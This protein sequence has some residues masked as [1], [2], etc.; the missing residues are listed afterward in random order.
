MGSIGG[1]D[2]DFVYDEGLA[3]KLKRKRFDFWD[4]DINTCSDTLRRTSK[5][6]RL[7]D[8]MNKDYKKF[9]KHLPGNSELRHSERVQK[10]E[11]RRS[12]REERPGKSEL[13]HSVREERDDGDGDGDGMDEDYKRFLYHLPGNSEFRHSVREERDDGDRSDEDD[14]ADPQYKMFLEKLKEDGKSYVLEVDINIKMS[15][16]RKYEVEVDLDDERELPTLR[17]LMKVPDTMIMETKKDLRNLSRKDNIKT[18]DNPMYVVS[19][20][21]LDPSNNKTNAI[22]I[23]R[24]D[25]LLEK[26]LNSEQVN[27][28]SSETNRNHLFK[29]ECEHGTEADIVMDEDYQTFLNLS[30]EEGDCMILA[31]HF[32][33]TECE[34]GTETSIVMDEDYQTL[35]NLSKEEG[36]CTVLAMK[37]GEQVTMADPGIFIKMQEDE[38][39]FLGSLD[40]GNHSEFRDKLVAKLREPYNNEEYETLCRLINGRKQMDGRHRDLRGPAALKSYLKD[41]CNL[42][43]LDR[44][45]NPKFLYLWSFSPFVDT[46]RAMEDDDNNSDEVGVALNLAYE[47]AFRPWLDPSYLE[48]L[49]RNR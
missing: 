36:D 10:S 1:S 41:E 30:K 17:K 24:R 45:M 43:Y 39:Q 26:D 31:N 27:H 18:Q 12:V 11:F 14:R 2:F 3:R 48:V 37:A 25:L 20:D 19:K 40:T 23:E 13:R 42:S 38:L 35:L 16:R 22:G 6:K 49:P 5:V 46:Y 4:V 21:M 7:D 28:V 34:Q 33:K 8:G 15:L 9:L 47:D 29:V 44:H 32:F